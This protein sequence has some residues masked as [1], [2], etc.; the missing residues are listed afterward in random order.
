LRFFWQLW[1]ARRRCAKLYAE[2]PADVVLAMGGFT[3]AAPMWEAQRLGVPTV[4]HEAN[5]I[6]GRANRLLARNAA[7]IVVGFKEA[8]AQFDPARVVVGGTPVRGELKRA[9]DKGSA[10]SGLGLTNASIVVL[11]TGGSQGA[12]GLNTKVLEALPH[13]PQGI[14]WLHLCGKGDETRVQDAYRQHGLTAK[15]WAFHSEMQK[16]YAAA[17]LVVARAGASSMTEINYFGLP[18]IYIPY[19][20][21]ADNHQSANAKVQVDG[22]AGICFEENELSGKTLAGQIGKLAADRDLR[23]RMGEASRRLAIPNAAEKLADLLCELAERRHSGPI[24]KV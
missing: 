8:A 12:R 19:P 6:A 16:L 9:L 1:R 11:V 17:D 21:A 15:V 7:R 10:R 24:L 13:L 2:F 4:V 20:H 18:A 14:E 23:M 22:G 3:S 5:V